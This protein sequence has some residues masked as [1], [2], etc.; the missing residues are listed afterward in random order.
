MGKV[1]VIVC[2]GLVDSS[3]QT[4]DLVLVQLLVCRILLIEKVSA[5]I[6]SLGK[7]GKVED[8]AAD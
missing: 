7:L 2:K 6:I 8:D 3:C 1:G 5:A 4:T